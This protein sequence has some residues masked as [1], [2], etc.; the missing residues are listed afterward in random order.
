[1]A[2]KKKQSKIDPTGMVPRSKTQPTAA[3]TSPGKKPTT[4]RSRSAAEKPKETRRTPIKNAESGFAGSGTPLGTSIGLSRPTAAKNLVN[5]GLT[6]ASVPMGAGVKAGIAKALLS[7]K[8]VTSVANA[9]GSAAYGKAAKGL[10]TSTGAGGKV[11]KTWTPMGKTLRSTQIGSPAQ[12]SARLANLDKNAQRIGDRAAAGAL[13]QSAINTIRGINK[14]GKI[15]NEG[16]AM[17]MI[18]KNR[19]KKK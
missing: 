3:F 5:V 9:A 19:P 4:T 18:A 11:S 15:V 17:G 16:A 12:Q 13:T 10:S 14:A 1:M 6:I 2:A 7:R 8:S